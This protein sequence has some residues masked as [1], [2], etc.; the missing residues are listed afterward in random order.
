[1]EGPALRGD[2]GIPVNGFSRKPFLIA[3]IVLTA[4]GGQ[5]PSSQT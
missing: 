4:G 1:M 5:F 3:V 2:E